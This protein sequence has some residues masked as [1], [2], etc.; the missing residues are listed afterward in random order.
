MEKKHSSHQKHSRPAFHGI[1]SSMMLV[2]L[3]EIILMMT[4]LYFSSITEQLNQNALAILQKQVENRQNYLQTMLV[5]NQELSALSD[6][7]NNTTLSLLHSG[8][9]DLE[10]LDQASENCLPLLNAVST[11]L[12]STLRYRSVTG[13]FLAL[14]THSFDTLSDDDVIPCVYIRDLDPDTAPSSRNSDLMLEVSPTQLVESMRIST[15]SAWAPTLRSGQSVVSQLLAPAFEA[16]YQDDTKLDA[17]D[18][19]HWTTGTYTLSGDSHAAIGYTIPLIL[20]DGT[21]YGVLGIE[22]LE[23]YVQSKLPCQELS[24][25]GYGTYLLASTTSATSNFRFQI[26]SS[27]CSTAKDAPLPAGSNDITLSNSTQ[28]GC[29]YSCNNVRYRAAYDSLTL[30]SRNAPFSGEQW[31]LVGVVP[32]STL[33]GFSKHVMRLLWIAMLLVLVTGVL[34]SLFAAHWFCRPISQLSDEVAAAQESRSSIPT[35]SPTGIVELDQFASAITQLSQDVISSSTR[36]LQIMDMAS[37]SLGGY[38]LRSDP[39]SIYVTDNFFPL[40]GIPDIDPKTLTVQH[41]GALMRHLSQS[42]MHKTTADGAELYQISQGDGSLRYIRLE[43][44]QNGSTR[45]GLV[46]DVTFTTEE[47]LRVEHERDYDILTGLYSRRAFR[48]KCSALFEQPQQLHH[49]ALLMLDLDNLKSTN[50]SLGHDWGDRYIQRAGQC[51]AQHAPSSALCSRISGDEFNIFLYG[52]SSR[53][54]LLKVI[55]R[56][57]HALEQTTI[58]L[59]DGREFNI[60]LSGGVAWYPDDTLDLDLLKK[61]ADFAMY[62]VK[63][64]HKG[65]L[66]EF[67]IA[68][69]NSSLHER[70]LRSEFHQML[71]NEA[72]SYHFQPIFSAKDGTPLAYE[73]LMRLSLPTLKSPLDVLRLARAENKLHDIER[74]T[75]FKASEAYDALQRSGKVPAGKLLFINTIASQ[76]LNEAEENEF[77]RRFSHLLPQYVSEITEEDELDMEA[78]EKKRRFPGGSQVF[79]LDDYGS[80]FNSEKNLLALAPH[81]IKVDICIVSGIDTDE[82]KQQIVANIVHYAHQRD[83]KIIAEGLETPAELK[84][85]LRL[86]V[87]MLQGYLLAKPAQVPPAISPEALDVIHS[88]HCSSGINGS[89]PV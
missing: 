13:I 31:L 80:G 87:D 81:Y 73:A 26:T 82:N 3:I 50:D 63:R 21:V 78:L 8:D 74:I 60:S 35:L 2:L 17:E 33:F 71:R 39:P 59:P 70:Q 36:F 43:T 72:I 37:V 89:D 16:A 65:Q 22:M 76:H 9:I 49:A 10:T 57:W 62:E 86:G 25:E 5:D 66:G 27:L 42:C 23:S 12:V 7:I 84:T 28:G 15:D 67:N 54:E 75:L 64:S 56:L 77:V 51:I 46:E 44:Q 1:L 41:F 20:P 14:R 11:N 69:Y 29:Y 40:L 19:G 32:E 34:S 88:F 18:Y 6:S 68:L 55:H 61:Y 30:Y 47:R 58:H 53:K 48:A 52:Y 45:M 83:M 4:V 79:A 24:S 85:L 38:E